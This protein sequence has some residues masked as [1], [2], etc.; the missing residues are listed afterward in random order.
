MSNLQ[1]ILTGKSSPLVRM[2]PCRRCGKELT[3]S[4]SRGGKYQVCVDCW[5]MG[6]RCSEHMTLMY[7]SQ[8]EDGTYYCPTKT[9]GA[10]C[11][12]KVNATTGK[13]LA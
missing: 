1:R 4:V 7:A 8:K 13:E 9:D 2:P 3:I 5:G 11:T 12:R 10:Y 6:P